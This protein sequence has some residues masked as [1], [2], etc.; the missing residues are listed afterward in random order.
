MSETVSGPTRALAAEFI[1]T[2]A[3]V[4]IGAGS[5]IALGVN[6]DPPVVLAHGLTIL[7]FVAAFGHVS[8]GHLRANASRSATSPIVTAPI[9]PMAPGPLGLSVSVLNR[10]RNDHCQSGLAQPLQFL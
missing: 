5:A 4:F 2:F 1:G 6:H 7:V 3:L 8:S 10:R 9:R